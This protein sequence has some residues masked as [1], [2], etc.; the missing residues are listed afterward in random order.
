[1]LE[2]VMNPLD[3]FTRSVKDICNRIAVDTKRT[4]AITKLRMDLTSHDRQR[5]ELFARLGERVDELRRTEQIS[6]KGL[7]ALLED[8]FE[9]LDRIEVK[10]GKTMSEIQKLNLGDYS[11]VEDESVGSDNKDNA[12]DS[13]N[14]L[15]SFNVL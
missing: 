14:L 12:T 6:D 8:E 7:L 3:D 1:M 11:V 13:G 4:A 10:I 9:N 2:T 15:D 5:R